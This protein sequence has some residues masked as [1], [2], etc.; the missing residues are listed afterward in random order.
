M[1]DKIVVIT[2]A[3]GG[4]GQAMTERYLRAKAQVILL[5]R[6]QSAALCA[7]T[8]IAARGVNTDKA[9]IKTLDLEDLD[10]VRVLAK[11]LVQELPRVDLLLLNAG[12]FRLPPK[13]NAAGLER[14]F[15]INY[16]GHYLLCA[17]LWPALLASGD[18]RIIGVNSATERKSPS[19]F[20]DP[21]SLQGQGPWKSYAFSK[22]CLL[23]FGL[24]LDARCRAAALPCRFVAADPGFVGTSLL[25]SGGARE[26]L[27]QKARNAFF[28]VN[29]RLLGQSPMQGSR[30]L[31]FASTED[32]RPY[33]AVVEPTGLGALWG[34]PGWA[35]VSRAAKDPQF[36]RELWDFS[37]S[38]APFDPSSNKVV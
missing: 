15:A 35:K 30:S 14:H 22:R 2:G 21:R 4:L 17:E 11:E 12:V 7:L 20:L 38:Y 6:R 10:Q 27:W 29:G 34:R 18:A 32:L 33:D 5:C 8:E 16:L 31:W 3:N 24:E 13:L 9:Q 26:S 25:H 37:Q 23:S 36:V 28:A 1:K 19:G